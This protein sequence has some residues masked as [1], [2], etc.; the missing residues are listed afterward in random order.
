MT[1]PRLAACLAP[2]LLAALPAAAAPAPA[3]PIPKPAT[4]AAKPA[5]R[6]QPW[7]C[8][9]YRAEQLVFKAK[10]R[11]CAR[12]ARHE[13]LRDW[14]PA[15]DP[16]EPSLPQSTPGA[17]LLRLEVDADLSG[18]LS[19]EHIFFEPDS[20]RVL[21]RTKVKLGSDPYRKSY[22]YGQGGLEWTRSAPRS[23]Q[24]TERA[25]PAWSK[26]ENFSAPYPPGGH[27]RTYSEAT[28]LLYLAAEHDWNSS[29]TLQLCMFAGKQWSRVE[30]TS[31]GLRAFDAAYRVDGHERKV[32]EARV[33]VLKASQAGAQV[34]DDPLELMGLRG[35]LE[36]Y[37]D[38]QS[39]LP[40]AI[41]G[42][43]PWLGMVTVRLEKAE[44][45]R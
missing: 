6:P 15:S 43:M 42:E 5:P 41:Q 7:S 9:D 11:V 24:E 1:R 8:L 38:P 16:K 26:I 20:G 28:L 35:D 36:L 21:Q 30:A 44:T 18:R 12:P 23:R 40:L 4:P 10:T 19:E 31:T 45:G 25:E 17:P 2:L 29:K 22:R 13:E 33:I 37:L 32:S 39:G 34:G 14:L 3:K 27:C